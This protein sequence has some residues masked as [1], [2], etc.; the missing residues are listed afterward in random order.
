MLSPNGTAGKAEQQGWVMFLPLCKAVFA[1]A[2][3]WVHALRVKAYD[4]GQ[5]KAVFATGL[6]AIVTLAMN[7]PG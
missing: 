1:T 3:P 2:R 6:E 5:Q 7:T 4:W